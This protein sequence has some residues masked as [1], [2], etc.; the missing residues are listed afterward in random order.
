MKHR[1]WE[2]SVVEGRCTDADFLSLESRIRDPPLPILNG[3]SRHS[4]LSLGPRVAELRLVRF[5]IAL[6]RIG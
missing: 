3:I 5:R 1:V 2:E 6:R 4:P